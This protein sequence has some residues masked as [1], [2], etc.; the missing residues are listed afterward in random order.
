MDLSQSPL[1]HIEY[2]FFPKTV[3]QDSDFL[4][5]MAGGKP[6]SFR[7]VQSFPLL[8]PSDETS[9]STAMPGDCSTS[10]DSVLFW[11]ITS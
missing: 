1:Q 10:S 2:Y 5:K 11:L 6:L 9:Q 7:G 8:P 3:F 4:S